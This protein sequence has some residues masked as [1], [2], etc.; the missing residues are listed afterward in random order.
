MRIVVTGRQGQ[1]VQSLLQAAAHTTERTVV[2]LGR[3]ELDLQRLSDIPGALA[4][5]APDVVVNAAAYTAVDRAETERDQALLI[6]GAAAGAVA[7]AAARLQV[8]VVQLSTDFVFDGAGTTPYSETDSTGPLNVY[9]A[10]KL[11]GE[12]LVAAA[13][14]RHLILR[15]SWVISPFGHNFARTMLRLGAERPHLSVVDDQHGA[16][17]YAPHLAVA[18]LTLARTMAK[19]PPADSR[20]GLYHATNQGET[21]WC[22]LARHIFARAAASGRIVPQV[23]AIPST[24]YPTPARRP[25][26]SRLDG[27]KLA[28]TFGIALPSWQEGADACVD[29]L[30]ASGG[31]TT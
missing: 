6:N 29:G 5:A 21:T 4:A 10:S 14:P 31:A 22:G 12:Q 25:H 30:L 19:A 9:G 3:P 23:A 24:G 8:P 17:T 18:I 16:P 27:G 7:A 13:N 11:L 26:N 2:A 28:A 20:W 15:T 1:V